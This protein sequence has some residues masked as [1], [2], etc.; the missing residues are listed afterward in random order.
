[1]WGAVA[2]AVFSAVVHAS[3]MAVRPPAARAAANIS[4]LPADEPEPLT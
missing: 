4:R 2:V 3:A 1:V